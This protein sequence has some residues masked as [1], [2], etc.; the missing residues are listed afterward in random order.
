MTK[1]TN[2]GNLE[3]AGRDPMFWGRASRFLGIDYRIHLKKRN[4]H[5]HSSK[6]LVFLLE[7]LNS[8]YFYFYLYCHFNG[9]GCTYLVVDSPCMYIGLW[10]SWLIAHSHLVV[11]ATNEH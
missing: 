2:G 11:R 1:A 10:Q 7:F 9:L 6:W 3:T 5:C 8:K 4:I